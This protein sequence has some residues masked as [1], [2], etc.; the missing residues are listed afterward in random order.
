MAP[1]SYRTYVRGH[2]G[3][4]KEE[5]ENE[6]D[7]ERVHP[8]RIGFRDRNDRVPG[9]VH[10]GD[11]SDEESDE[12]DDAFRE[13]AK[14]EEDELREKIKKHGLVNFREAKKKQEVC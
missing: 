3:S 8:H 12:S 11:E 1:V 10:Q 4:T 9:L 2:P 6:P 5:I 7:W 13:Q 14:K